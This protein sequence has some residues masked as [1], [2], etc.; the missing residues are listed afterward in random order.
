VSDITQTYSLLSHSLDRPIAISG[1]KPVSREQFLRDISA[2]ASALPD[3]THVINLCR[4]RY[5]FMV[6]FFA[7]GVR[8]LVNLLP[9]GQQSAYIDE[10]RTVY[11]NACAVF[12]DDA[13]RPN[14]P[15]FKFPSRL[16]SPDV[17]IG[18]PELSGRQVAAIIFTSGSTGTSKPIEKT[19]RTLYE[20]ALLNRRY[21]F[22]APT[23][24]G[25]LFATVPPWHMYGLEWSFML[26]M[27]GD[28]AV[29]C[30]D[31]FFPDD[32]RAALQSVSSPRMLI[33]TPLHLRALVQSGL[34]FPEIAGVLCATSPL[35]PE[36][37]ADVENRLTTELL[38]IYGCSEIGSMARRWPARDADWKFFPELNIR[39]EDDAVFVS[40]DYVPECVELADSLAF[41]TEGG[42]LLEGRR[43]DMI[44]V[45]GKRITLGELNHRL[46]AIKGVVDGVFFDPA[47]MGFADTERLGALVVTDG[48][49]AEDVRKAL[50]KCM[51]PV[52]LP[53]PLRLV[54]RLPRLD[55]GKLSLEQ[56]RQLIQALD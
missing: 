37:A 54:P 30:G 20:G 41:N 2:C 44:K 45:A 46:L 40:A 17:P 51:D 5:R 7:A 25:I 27:V 8:G 49:S 50:V 15:A 36:L 19:W 53:R 42:F 9:P 1:G 55:T 6:A 56:L 13:A 22:D 39:T 52:F 48:L 32:I 21:F 38:E 18:V 23:T 35:S 4:D 10:I 16:S 34:E 12:D 26:P 11:P 24:T 3:E 43:T 33:T 29:Y 31:T 28:F 47:A 14:G